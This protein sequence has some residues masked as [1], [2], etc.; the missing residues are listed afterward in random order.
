MSNCLFTEDHEWVKFDGN[1]AYVGIT[2]HAAEELGEI[3]YV[4]LLEDGSPIAKG[5]EFG[6]VESVKTVSGLYSPVTGKIVGVNQ[7]AID[8]PEVINQS[9]F[10]DGWLLKIEFEN[11]EEIE[12][13][14]NESDYQ[15]FLQTLN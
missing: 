12:E 14:M 8:S 6:S 1:T 13:L 9:P 2:D 15:S 3:V 5:D 4:E 10:D 11:S 7:A